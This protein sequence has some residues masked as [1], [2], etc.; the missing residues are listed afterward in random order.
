M[1]LK[2][3]KSKKYTK[4]IIQNKIICGETL[5]ALKKMPSNS[6]QTIITSPDDGTIAD[7]DH[8]GKNLQITD[9]LLVIPASKKWNTSGA[10]RVYIYSRAG[11]N[12]ILSKTAAIWT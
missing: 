5:G 6:V 11:S 9:D 4:N 1:I 7:Y 3:K 8:F 10:G 12:W 2:D